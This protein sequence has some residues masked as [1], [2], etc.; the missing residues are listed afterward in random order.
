MFTE[1]SETVHMLNGRWIRTCLLIAPL[2]GVACGDGDAGGG[3]GDFAGTVTDSAGVQ[4]VQNTTDGLWTDG[5]GWTVEEILTIGEAAGDPDYQFGQVVAVDPMSDGRIAVL[6]A[7]AQRVQIYGADGT[8]QES[9][10][11]PGNGPGEFS[12]GTGAL[13]VGRG[14]TIVVP[15]MGNQ[16][17]TLIPPEGDASSFP[18]QLEQGIPMRFDLTDDGLLVSQRRAMNFGD[19]SAET[20][21]TDLILE[22]RYNGELVDTLLTPRRGGTFEMS[23]G[24]PKIKLFAPEPMWTMLSDDRLAF[25]SN[26]TYRINV[27]GPDGELQQ[28]VQFPHEQRPVTEREQETVRRAIRQLWEENGVPPQAMDQ[29][30]SSM[31]FA[32]FWPAF[33]QMRRGPR[34]TLW[35]QRI[36]DL[37]SMSDE[38]L[39]NWNPQ[40]DSGAPEWDV[41]EADGRYGGMIEMP[42]R[43]TPLSIEED[44]IYGI[45]RDDFDV[46]YVRVYRLDTGTELGDV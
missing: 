15:D 44:R 14:D 23:S 27:Y 36:R 43:F 26:D 32:Q 19:P 45:F 1:R 28:I 18:L 6:D 24:G 22:Q 11:G 42:A 30:M 34:G 40:S 2:L 46:Q 10:G 7:Q 38:D 39:Q 13:F 29:M 37:E 12:A 31:S 33:T 8:Y 3:S 9:I 5:S 41:F 16:R 20:S 35:V 4:I 21:P 17:I 25:A